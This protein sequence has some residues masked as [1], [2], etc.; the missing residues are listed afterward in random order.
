M[1]SCI[2][3]VFD[4]TLTVPAAVLIQSI[5]DNYHD[6]EGLDIVCCIPGESS[7]VFKKVTSMLKIRPR[8]KVKL[9]SVNKKAFPWLDTLDASTS[10][11]WAPP[12]E[13]YKLFLGSFLPDYDKV[14]YFDTDMLVVN[15]IQPILDHPQYREFMAV[16]DVSGTE[17]QFL[18]SRGELAYLNNGVMIIDLNWW[19]DTGIEKIMLNHLENSPHVRVASE[20]MCNIYLKDYWYPLPFTFNF[21]KFSRGNDEIPNYDESVGL[22][23]HYKHVIAFHFA[24]Q[25]K[26]WNFK[27]IVKREDTSLLGQK[28]RRM[29]EAA[30]SLAK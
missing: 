4:E 24:G 16:V 9:V 8:I 25:E 17:F 19:R 23:E 7:A 26:P 2:S 3:L 27:E 22:P 29:A 21:Y 6:N 10:D 15:N 30:I 11:H 18:K 20:E 12:I 28:W 5:S 14:I 13:R 1:K